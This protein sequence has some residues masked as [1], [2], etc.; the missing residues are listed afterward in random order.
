MRKLNAI[1]VN[2]WISGIALGLVAGSAMYLIRS[3][4]QSEAFIADISS[5]RPQYDQ[6]LHG[7]N[8]DE[9]DLYKE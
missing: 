3:V 7:R 4:S 1:Q 5:T 6:L 9:I 8:F 2:F